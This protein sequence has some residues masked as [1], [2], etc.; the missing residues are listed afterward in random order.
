MQA[1][2][3]RL[4]HSLFAVYRIKILKLPS[5]QVPLNS[6]Y[7]LEMRLRQLSCDFD[8]S[9]KMYVAFVCGISWRIL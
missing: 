4:V 7:S 8:V 5:S 2:R 3:I 9:I 1:Q 6:H